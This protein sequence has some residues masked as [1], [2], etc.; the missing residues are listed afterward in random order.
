MPASRLHRKDFAS[1]SSIA[2]HEVHDYYV[3]EF[4]ELYVSEKKSEMDKYLVFREIVDLL[5]IQG[6]YQVEQY[7]DGM[8]FYI[9]IIFFDKRACGLRKRNATHKI[10]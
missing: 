3:F 4:D 9:L 8:P 6:V 1:Y 7:A 5:S 10:P 2:R